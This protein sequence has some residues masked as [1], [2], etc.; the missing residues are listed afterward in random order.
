V[1]KYVERIKRVRLE[2]NRQVKV[3]GADNAGYQPA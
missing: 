2:P 3:V 1:S